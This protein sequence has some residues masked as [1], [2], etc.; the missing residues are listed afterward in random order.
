MTQI[1]GE[2]IRGRKENWQVMMTH[3]TLPSG[4]DRGELGC[5]TGGSS[6]FAKVTSGRE[7]GKTP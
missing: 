2:L 7:S 4:V 1:E 6:F 3:P 5:S